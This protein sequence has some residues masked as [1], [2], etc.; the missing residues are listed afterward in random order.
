[1][2]QLSPEGTID[3]TVSRHYPFTTQNVKTSYRHTTLPCR[4]ERRLLEHMTHIFNAYVYHPFL[5]SQ[6]LK[7]WNTAVEDVVNGLYDDFM[8]LLHVYNMWCNAMKDIRQNHMLPILRRI[9]KSPDTIHEI[10][11]SEQSQDA[12]KDVMRKKNAPGTQDIDAKTIH[13]L[14]QTGSH[15]QIP[16]RA[17]ETYRREHT[18]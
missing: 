4:T 15:R 8:T 3:R 11:I 10:K 16:A 5:Q 12:L 9:Q 6:Q 14:E 1:M 17:K 18:I 7:K 2:V 13:L